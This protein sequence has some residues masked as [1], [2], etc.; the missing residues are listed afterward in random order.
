MTWAEIEHHSISAGVGPLRAGRSAPRRFSDEE[1][2]AI[3]AVNS[4]QTQCPEYLIEAIN[5]LNAFATYAEECSLR[6][7]TPELYQSVQVDTS[8]ARAQLETALET[9]L[10]QAE[11]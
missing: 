2:I 8:L 1:L 10:G 7:S 3:A 4:D 9:M 11:R 5:Q 6:S